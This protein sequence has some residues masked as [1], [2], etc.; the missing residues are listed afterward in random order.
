MGRHWGRKGDIHNKMRFVGWCREE[1][2]T[3]ESRNLEHVNFRN[4]TSNE[5]THMERKCPSQ[6]QKPCHGTF[7]V[8]E[9]FFGNP[10]HEKIQI[11][12]G[13]S[14]MISLRFIFGRS[15]AGARGLAF[16][17]MLANTSIPST[18][19]AEARTPHWKPAGSLNNWLSMMGKTIPP[20]EEPEGLWISRRESWG[21]V[22]NCVFEW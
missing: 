22:R 5:L 11:K 21:G 4:G 6:W 17:N 18:M 2:R 7:W 10:T 13:L 16:I 15:A 20:R 1:Q 3:I 19:N 12:Y 14:V 8:T 9:I